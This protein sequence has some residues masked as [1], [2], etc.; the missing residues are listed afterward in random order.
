MSFDLS[1]KRPACD[2]CGRERDS[3]WSRSGITHN[4]NSIVDLCIGSDVVA[5]DAR[6]GYAERSWGRLF[7]WPASE[8]LP[9]VVRALDVANDTA[10]E[11]EFRALEPENG[12]GSLEGVRDAFADLARA[13]AEH[14]KAIF[15]AWG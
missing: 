1:L 7:G 2:Y 9:I 3:V 14:P 13:C 10:R 8:A 12:W 15:E 5:R 4:V 11:A 6:A